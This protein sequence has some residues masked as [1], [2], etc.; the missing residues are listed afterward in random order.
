[1]IDTSML[2]ARSDPIRIDSN[3]FK[4]WKQH[5]TLD[6][7]RGKRYGQS[8]CDYFDITDYILYY[9]QEPERCDKYIRRKYIR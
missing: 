6:A 7:L 2:V 5:Y 9:T 1:M 8:F 3:E 4:C